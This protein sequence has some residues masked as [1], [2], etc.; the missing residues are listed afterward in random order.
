MR[1]AC[2]D[3][4]LLDLGLIFEEMSL[5]SVYSRWGRITPVG[6]RE[7]VD[8]ASDYRPSAYPDATV[9]DSLNKTVYSSL[10]LIADEGDH[11]V[12]MVKQTGEV[13]LVPSPE[14]GGATTLA[15]G[16]VGE[17][18]AEFPGRGYEFPPLTFTARPSGGGFVIRKHKKPFFEVTYIDGTFY[19]AAEIPENEIKK[20]LYFI[21]KF[22]EMP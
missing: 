3:N 13:F 11:C 14:N 2:F 7:M 1:F 5:V 21:N 15:Y 10:V 16:T 18:I 6:L 4:V 9:C 17:F 20:A 19:G 12:W 8:M 22:F